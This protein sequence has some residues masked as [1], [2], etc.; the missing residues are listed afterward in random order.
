MHGPPTRSTSEQHLAQARLVPT[1][2][3]ADIAGQPARPTLWAGAATTQRPL[4]SASERD[5]VV[6]L[7][8]P[9]EWMR[10]Y[11]IVMEDGTVD[12]VEH[13]VDAGLLPRYWAQM[14]LS[15]HVRRAWE[16]LMNGHA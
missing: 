13:L 9:G 8:D 11:A 16:P 4:L 3:S 15:P 5:S 6:D 12:D 7:G 10:C 14:W 2:R 1:S